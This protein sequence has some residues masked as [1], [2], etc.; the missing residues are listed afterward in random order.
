MGD[1]FE[2]DYNDLGNSGDYT[3]SGGGSDSFLSGGIPFG[4]L[5]S[6]VGTG[7]PSA[8]YQPTMGAFPAAGAAGAAMV[9][10]LVSLGARLAGMFGR[11]A[12]VASINGVKFA[13]SSLWPYIRKYGPAAVASAL[14]IG[15]AELGALAMQAPQHGRK[16]RRGISAA[17]I[18]RTKR[19]IRFNR[20]LSRSLGTGRSRGGYGRPR[21]RP[22]YYC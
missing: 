6:L 17:D 16:R 15:L 18:T 3:A 5:Q 9:G 10:G 7:G 4:T 22:A 1:D 13:M 12:G 19:V 21:R 20:Q 11:G 14:G 2:L 8:V